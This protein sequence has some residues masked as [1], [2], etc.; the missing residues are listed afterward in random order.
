MKSTSNPDQPIQD[1]DAVIEEIANAI[2][3]GSPVDLE[4]YAEDFPHFAEQ[5]RNIRSVSD[6]PI[7]LAETGVAG[8]PGQGQQIAQLFASLRGYR[9]FGLVWF[10]LNRKQPWRLEGRPAGLAAYR[11]AVGKLRERSG[12]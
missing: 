10:D 11:K 1:L 4:R 8:G 3:S 7:Y 12:G 5:L 2:A 6:R 9:L